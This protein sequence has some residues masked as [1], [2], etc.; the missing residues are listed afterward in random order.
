[1]S[2]LMDAA[3]TMAPEGQGN[4]VGAQPPTTQKRAGGHMASQGSAAKVGLYCFNLFQI[5]LV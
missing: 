2:P 1:M 4:S 3:R 5:S